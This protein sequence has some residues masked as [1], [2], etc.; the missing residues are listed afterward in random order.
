MR[1]SFSLEQTGRER[2]TRLLHEG[3]THMCPMRVAIVWVTSLKTENR[4]DSREPNLSSRHSHAC[5]Q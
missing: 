5:V 2:L 4:S 1:V 3:L